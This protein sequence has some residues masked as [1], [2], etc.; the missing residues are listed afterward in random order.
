MPQYDRTWRTNHL[1]WLRTE[2]GCYTTPEDHMD[3]KQLVHSV[4]S[5]PV[6]SVTPGCRVGTDGYGLTLFQKSV[7]SMVSKKAV[8]STITPSCMRRY[9]VYVLL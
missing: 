5:C 8:A 6:P 1:T 2:P 7:N 9:Q 4:N 3:S